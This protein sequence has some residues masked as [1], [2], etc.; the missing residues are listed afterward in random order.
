MSRPGQLVL[1]W[2]PTLLI[3]IEAVIGLYF[4][5]ALF[6]PWPSVLAAWDNEPPPSISERLIAVILP[7]L[8]VAL[9]LAGSVI[10][11]RVAYQ[12]ELGV[13]RFGR[14]VLGGILILNVLALAGSVQSIAGERDPADLIALSLFIAV[15]M[16]CAWILFQDGWARTRQNPRQ[17][18]S[19]RR[20][21]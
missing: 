9:L 10:A 12:D 18:L 11:G 19:G 5:V 21:V 20:R 3:S 4:L 8:F 7:G 13:G 6:V 17:A 14:I 15:S 1:G 16:G 2:L